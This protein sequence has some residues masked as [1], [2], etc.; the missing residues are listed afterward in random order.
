MRKESISD[1]NNESFKC[2]HFKGIENDYLSS[3]PPCTPSLTTVS[4]K[5][6]INISIST[7][8]DIGVD[9]ISYYQKGQQ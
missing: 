1:Y 4:K 6:K 9:C 2:M 7:Y 8:K 3:M 5:N